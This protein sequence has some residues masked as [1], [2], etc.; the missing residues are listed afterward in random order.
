[1]AVYFDNTE[2]IDRSMG[3][4]NQFLSYFNKNYLET[5]IEFMLSKMVVLRWHDI[6]T[7]LTDSEKAYN[8]ANNGPSREVTIRGSAVAL[9]STFYEFID[10]QKLTE[11][12]DNMLQE[13]TSSVA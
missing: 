2:S 4:E 13:F 12:V 11:L 5:L 6:H 1:M 10:D 9:L 8:D 3:E 7:L